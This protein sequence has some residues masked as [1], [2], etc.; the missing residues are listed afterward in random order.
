MAE[1]NPPSQATLEQQQLVGMDPNQLQPQQEQQLLSMSHHPPPHLMGLPPQLAQ[2][3]HMQQLQLQ[4]PTQMPSLPQPDQQLVLPQSNQQLLAQPDSQ[5]TLL[6]LLTFSNRTTVKK[7]KKPEVNK[8][9]VRSHFPKDLIRQSIVYDDQLSAIQSSSPAALREVAKETLETFYRCFLIPQPG[10]YV[11]NEW[12]RLYASLV[13]GCVRFHTSDGRAVTTIL[14]DHAFKEEGMSRTIEYRAK[15][16]HGVRFVTDI[17]FTTE[18]EEEGV[19][20]SRESLWAHFH[21]SLVKKL[22]EDEVLKQALLSCPPPPPPSKKFGSQS[23][24]PYEKALK[25]SKSDDKLEPATPQRASGN[26]LN[27]FLSPFPPSLRPPASTSSSSVM[28][29]F[30]SA[31]FP[32]STS[33]PLFQPMSPSAPQL[34]ATYELVRTPHSYIVDFALPA[35]SCV[36]RNFEYHRCVTGRSCCILRACGLFHA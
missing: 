31:S 8:E 23:L 2:M 11:N 34:N 5:R 13:P 27:S 21:E 19:R 24:N 1:S 22:T 36:A 35:F 32:S 15:T 16:I 14:K 28:P 20:R 25:K 17:E 7:R 26:Q 4:V 30:T 6:P 10:F 3:S 29:S 18:Y 12:R 33:G 9:D